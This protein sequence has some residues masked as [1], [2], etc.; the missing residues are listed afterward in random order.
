[1]PNQPVRP[2]DPSRNYAVLAL[3]ATA[4]IVYGS[5]YPFE[6][7]IPATGP[8]AVKMLLDSLGN[9]LHRGDFIANILFYMPFG[10]FGMLTFCRRLGFLLSLLLVVAAG[11]LLS[12]TMELTQYYD[13][14]RDTEIS[15]VCANTLGTTIGAVAATPFSGRWRLPFAAEIAANPAPALLIAA[16]L[17]YR[18]YPYVPTI[19]LHKYWT[20]LKP[21]LLDPALTPYDVYRHAT[22]WLTLFAL[23]EAIVG[24]R[25]SV[26]IFVP[27]VAAVLMA[28]VMNVATVLSA[29]E[30]AG[31]VVAIW[32]WPILLAFDRRLRL[33]MLALL[34]GGY[35]LAAR[36]EPFHFQAFARPFGWVPFRAFVDGAVEINVLSFLEKCF[37]YGSVLFMLG[38]V[39]MRPWLAA[40]LVAG[41]LFATSWAQTLLPGRSAEITDALLALLLAAGIALLGAARPRRGPARPSV[42]SPVS[43]RNV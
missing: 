1:V 39:G 20:A 35:V 9:P 4:A 30:I 6:L 18:L 23:I 26:L 27:F 36:L 25:R 38:A 14:G 3:I 21:V 29:P 19:D 41:A 31:A 8:G 24:P 37:L 13:V 2:R 16:W 34:L 33:I 42:G 22:V 40:L 7:G 43:D 5:L 12:L 11:I 10:F 28:R 15:D 32:L 17:G